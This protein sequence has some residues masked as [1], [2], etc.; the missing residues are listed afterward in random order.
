MADWSQSGAD[1][2]AGG[3]TTRTRNGNGRRKH[4]KLPDM[5]QGVRHRFRDKRRS[6]SPDFSLDDSASQR[7]AYYG[8][9]S[10]SGLPRAASMLSTDCG[11]TEDW[12]HVAGNSSSSRVMSRHSQDVL[13]QRGYNSI[14]GVQNNINHCSSRVPNLTTPGC[15]DNGVLSDCDVIHHSNTSNI[16]SSTGS[17]SRLTGAG[18]AVSVNAVNQTGLPQQGTNHRNSS[19]SSM[20]RGKSVR[21]GENRISVFLQDS[22]QALEECVRL[23]LSYAEESKRGDYCSDTEAVTLARTLN[24]S[25]D[26]NS[27]SFDKKPTTNFWSDSEDRGQ[28]QRRNNYDL[29]TGKSEGPPTPT[30]YK[31][32]TFGQAVNSLDRVERLDKLQQDKSRK[33]RSAQINEIFSFIDKILSGCDN[34]CSDEF[35]PFARD[36]G[37]NSRRVPPAY[38]TGSE[39]TTNQHKTYRFNS[40]VS[41]S[42]E[43]QS[44]TFS[45]S[46][47]GGPSSDSY[48]YTEKLVAEDQL[49]ESA[50]STSELDGSSSGCR[51]FRSS[52]PLAGAGFVSDSDC[53]I[54][55]S[56]T[57]VARHRPPRSRLRKDGRKSQEV[58]RPGPG[59]KRTTEDVFAQI[60]ICCESNQ[61]KLGMPKY[62]HIHQKISQTVCDAIFLCK[63]KHKHVIM[64]IIIVRVQFCFFCK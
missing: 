49:R 7:S 23:A 15:S 4:W 45:S 10:T 62:R 17:S 5:I 48:A 50:I 54:S 18:R 53:D 58:T 43:Y 28:R 32:R 61:E 36:N 51:S 30:S 56:S 25:Q 52:T 64:N 8:A 35:C 22:T 20:Q 47:P 39:W 44:K 37:R 6:K 13:Q 16:S 27:Q 55:E 42:S 3:V 21:F 57:V 41:S 31:P 12:R 19:S 59:N 63:V 2:V 38:N 26:V 29:S 1:S 60:I 9:P 46:F 14:S 11:F 40:T 33:K 24:Q 34:G